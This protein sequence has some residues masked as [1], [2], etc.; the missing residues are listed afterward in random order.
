MGKIATETEAYNIGKIGSPVTNKCCTKSRAEA[1]GCAVSGSYV[2]NRLVQKDDLSRKIISYIATFTLINGDSSSTW[3][4]IN[5]VPKNTTGFVYFTYL[6]NTQVTVAFNEGE[7]IEVNDVNGGNTVALP[8]GST[9]YVYSGNRPHRR[10]AQF[11]H[12][13]ENY[14]VRFTI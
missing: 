3:M 14:E 9:G 11:I 1:L 13:N 4:L 7:G 12:R 2:T 10:L 8:I 6:G 5:G